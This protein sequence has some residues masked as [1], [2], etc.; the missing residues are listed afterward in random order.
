L[1]GQS[2]RDQQA[3]RDHEDF[4]RRG[5]AAGWAVPSSAV[6]AWMGTTVIE[7]VSVV[8]VIVNYLFPVERRKYA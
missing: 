3:S 2:S 1:T 5:L 6:T 8:L 7:V 4:E